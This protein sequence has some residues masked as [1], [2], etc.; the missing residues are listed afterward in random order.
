MEILDSEGQHAVR[1]L[2]DIGAR[3]GN[4]VSLKLM[5]SSAVVATCERA[6]LGK[7][8]SHVRSPRGVPLGRA[9]LRVPSTEAMPYA[10]LATLNKI[11]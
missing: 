8:R 1:T 9:F 2:N 4:I 7:C 6:R 5:S 11:G 3:V 10:I